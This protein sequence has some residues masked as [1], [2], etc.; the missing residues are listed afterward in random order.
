[1]GGGEWWRGTGG[2]GWAG[3]RWQVFF[4]LEGE[5]K[6]GGGEG[7]QGRVGQWRRGEGQ[8]GTAGEQWGGPDRHASIFE[9]TLTLAYKRKTTV[10]ET[11][12]RARPG[13]PLAPHRAPA[14]VRSINSR[15]CGRAPAAHG[16][17]LELRRLS[18]RPRTCLL[19]A[20]GG[21]VFLCMGR[22]TPGAGGRN[23]APP[24][25]GGRPAVPLPLRRR[26]VAQAACRRRSLGPRQ[27]PA[28]K[29]LVGGGDTPPRTRRRLP[30]LRLPR[31]QSC[32]SWNRPI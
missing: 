30:R 8:R 19:A 20:G 14:P 21:S 23:T 5:G 16:A 9:E 6:R 32:V 1:M 27:G 13:L 12:G 26:C 2:G 11:V 3:W 24:S 10:F 25:S 22:P 31:G 17:F 4:F 29:D 15:A 28:R 7:W 18:Q